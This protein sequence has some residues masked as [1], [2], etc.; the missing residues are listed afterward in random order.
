M[1]LEIAL[2][3]AAGINIRNYQPLDVYML[4]GKIIQDGY[5]TKLSIDNN[6]TRE[7]VMRELMTTPQLQALR[8]RV[9]EK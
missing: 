3:T 4:G 1:K 8:Q 5:L 6:A 7:F 2:C 9:L